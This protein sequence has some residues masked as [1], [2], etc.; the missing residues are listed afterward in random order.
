MKTNFKNII[1]LATTGFFVFIFIA[2]PFIAFSAATIKTPTKTGQIGYWSFND[3]YGTKAGDSSGSGSTGTLVNSPTWIGGK[4][5]KALLFNGN[6]TYV[7]IPTTGASSTAG[8]ISF[9]AYATTT[10]TSGGYLLNTTGTSQRIY[11]NYQSSN[12]ISL[13]LGSTAVTIGSG[14]APL[15]KWHHVVGQWSGTTGTLYV[16][17][18]LIANTTFTALSSVLNP[19]YVGSFSGAQGFKGIIDDV[20]FYNRVLTAS[21]IAT[22]YKSGATVQ[23][24]SVNTN[25]LGYW[26]LNGDYGDY[27]GRKNN[28]TVYG[29]CLSTSTDAVT[30]GISITN[31][32]TCGTSPQKLG[33]LGTGNI[34]NSATEFTFVAWV[35]GSGLVWSGSPTFWLYAGAS[36]AY[37]QKYTSSWITVA[38]GSGG[39]TSSEWRQIVVTKT[40]V[41]GIKIY[42][43]TT[44]IA[45]STTEAFYTPTSQTIGRYSVYD[46]S[47]YHFT[48]K[49]DDIRLYNKVL[50]QSEINEL[51][52]LKPAT[53]NSSQNNKIT[54][55]L[56]GLWSFDGKDMNW[57]SNTALDRSG[58]GNN[59]RLMNMSTTT[60]PAP[61]KIGSALKFVASFTRYVYASNSS[62]INTGTG[63][64]SV[65]AW[66]KGST[67]AT[68]ND[69]ILQKGAGSF[70]VGGNGWE[71]RSR[72]ADAAL[73]F[74][75]NG[76]SGS[77]PRIAV[78][79][80]SPFNWK[81]VV[82]VVSRANTLSTMY[83]NGVA[84]GSMAHA[85]TFT[86]SYQF[87][88]GVG[89][90]TYY[91]GTIDDVRLYNRALSATE[92]KQ[93]YYL[94][95]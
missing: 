46:D 67:D 10:Q 53:V 64:F 22:I 41:G 79:G 51:Y 8:T 85:P 20:R 5:G 60:S 59:G 94:G 30:G 16:D 7:T 12:N 65:S 66:Y 42:S 9:W 11:F 50:S 13:L 3:N 92:A 15:G 77:C 38:T 55:G 87:N 37:L 74:C 54:S 21:E 25:L 73:E 72:S 14:P 39:G 68:G 4:F 45:S 57:G 90:D 83:V 40:S 18:V 1:K 27:S 17:G 84:V 35:K 89:H 44:E 93:L 91:R 28:F 43:N 58:N 75:V 62:S 78:A 86:D 6:D 24:N 49:I 47:G 80:L 31:W 69:D 29:T 23:K 34:F 70:N 26:P 76:G 82:I 48:G 32:A 56:V 2:T 52:K 36:G 88:I 81:H 71:L 33:Y 61:G 19:M 95:R 63:D